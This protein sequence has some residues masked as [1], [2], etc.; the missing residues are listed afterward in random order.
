M[1]LSRKERL[2][3]VLHLQEKL[4]Q[5][6]ET[7]HAMHVSKA[8]AAEKEAREIS[9]RIGQ[10]DSLSEIFPE[11]YHRRVANANRLRMESLARARAEAERASR[12]NARS[13]IVERSY[14]EA[15]RDDD[16]QRQEKEQLEEIERRT[17][18]RK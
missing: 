2:K 7:R 16:R 13:D 3:K 11:I 17:A 18:T 14:R 5:L 6:H 1:A 9:D 10:E 8:S 15:L 4:K 12:A